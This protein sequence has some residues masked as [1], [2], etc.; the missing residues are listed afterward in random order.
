MY[1]R[2]AAEA[3]AKATANALVEGDA[4]NISVGQGLSP[5]K[6][7]NSFKL[8]DTGTFQLT[9]FKMSREGFTNLDAAAAATTASKRHV[10]DRRLQGVKLQLDDLEMTEELGQGASGIVRKAVHTPTGVIVAVKTVNIAD[11]GKRAQMT[12]ELRALT[13]ADCPF[14]VA[15]LDA[16]YEEMQVHM[17]LEFMDGGDLSDLVA[18]HRA[19]T[20]TGIRDETALFKIATQVL[21]GL[22]Y[23]H[24]QRHQV[25]GERAGVVELPVC[26]VAPARLRPCAF[27]RAILSARD[28][29]AHL[30]PFALPPARPCAAR[31]APRCA[32]A[33]SAQVH[34][35][36][37]PANLML[38]KE[39]LVKISDFGISSELDSTMGMC[40]TF[41]GTA[42]YMSPERLS[43][44]EYSYPSDIWSFGLI[45]LELIV[46]EY[47]YPNATNYFQL[48]NNII[49]GDVPAVPSTCALSA[50]LV[51][52][53]KVCL[54][55]EPAQRP[56]VVELEAHPW[57]KLFGDADEMD[58]SMKLDDI[59]L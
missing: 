56:T 6:R 48:L 10:I 25:G 26:C 1:E 5:I 2:E 43:G 46:G 45:M 13:Q 19:S 20:G 27:S 57:M 9:D 59:K 42:N 34:R 40:D 4:M 29:A 53:V 54:S 39:G 21:S 28:S 18:A 51:D 35:D 58:L 33:A 49:E 16:F 17:V 47:P 7:R 24:R 55:K 30:T 15:L 50:E 11:K 41:V 37:K 52:F 14:L 38:T 36:M 23:L 44:G 22:S 3:E 31:R 32:A 12:K 8:T